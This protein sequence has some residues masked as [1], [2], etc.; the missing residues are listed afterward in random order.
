MVTPWTYHKPPMPVAPSPQKR[1]STAWKTTSVATA[2]VQAIMPIL[3]L[4][5]GVLHLLYRNPETLEDPVT[6]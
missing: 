4:T 1:R 3:A 6:V 2:V 5:V